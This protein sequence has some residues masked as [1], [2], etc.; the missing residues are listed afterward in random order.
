MIRPPSHPATLPP[1]QQLKQ[2]SKSSSHL[3]VTNMQPVFAKT[4]LCKWIFTSKKAQIII[5]NSIHN[6]V[7]ITMLINTIVWW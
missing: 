4:G 6:F 5:V 7:I 1:S 3:K 2:L